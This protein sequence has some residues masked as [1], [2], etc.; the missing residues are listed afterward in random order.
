MIKKKIAYLK[1]LIFSGHERSIKA[2]KNIISLF[3]VKGYSVLI[4]L[5]LIP[6]T[7]DLLD[8]YKY[9]IW[10]T[11]FNFLSMIQIFDI[12]IGNGLRNKLAEAIA[13][14]DIEGAKE[15]VS[16]SYVVMAALSLLLILLFLVPWH[17]IEWVRVFNTGIDIQVELKYLI[18]VCFVLTV[19]QFFLNLINSILTAYH[20]PA[21]PSFV[22]AISNSVILLIFVIFKPKINE[23]LLTIG[24]IYVITPIISF[25]IFSLWIFNTKYREI[26]PSVLFYNKTKVKDLFSLGGSFFIIQFA[27]LI[28]FQTDA[29]IISH[30][31]SPKEVTPYSIVYKYFSI[32]IMLTTIILTPLWSAYTEAYS[33]KDYSWVKD[34]IRKQLKGLIAI[35]AIIIIMLI[36]SKILIGIWIKQD[37]E[38]SWVLLVGTALFSIISVWNNIFAI[39]L[40][41]ISKTRVQIITSIVALLI[42]I[43]LSIYLAKIFGGGGV[44]LATCI[45]LSFFAIFGAIESF[46]I[47]KKHAL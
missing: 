43:P 13:I 2:K 16:T 4:S 25:L 17:F 38:L 45:S 14:N 10:I 23:S 27:G 11:V 41:G 32:A 19:I 22:F 5:A 30:T 28:I 47:L 40:N 36:F 20:K 1:T 37:L 8:D 42:N 21:Y 3:F 35:I 15:Y 44:I 9:G 26:K 39:F 29:L 46:S 18:G 24:T 6:V 7:L 12:G 31:L 33:K 34:I